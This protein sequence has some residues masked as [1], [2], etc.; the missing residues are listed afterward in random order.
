[1][2]N[3]YDKPVEHTGLYYRQIGVKYDERPILQYIYE[4]MVNSPY[5]VDTIYLPRQEFVIVFHNPTPT[6]A[7]PH[8]EHSISGV[9][10]VFG[11]PVEVSNLRQITFSFSDKEKVAIKRGN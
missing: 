7:V 10:K 3:Y 11:V 2:D 1:M 5:Q 6:Y 4:I 9:S 8:I